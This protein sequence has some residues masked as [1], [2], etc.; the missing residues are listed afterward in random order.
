MA[1]TIGKLSKAA[2]VPIDTIRYY[3]K[4]GVLKPPVRLSSGYRIYSDKSVWQLNFVRNAQK[5]GF[6][7]QEIRDLLLISNGE[8]GSCIH[9]RD[10]LRQK[11]TEIDAKLRSMRLLRG[12]VKRDLK[13]CE[14]E[15]HKVKKHEADS[16]PVLAEL[17]TQLGPGDPALPILPVH[18]GGAHGG[19]PPGSVGA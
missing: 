11:L 19:R 18:L 4:I 7:L 13:L 12:T 1:Y 9:V 16:C 10:R 8:S 6:L 5:L 15:L 3:E 17:S 2:S 14:E